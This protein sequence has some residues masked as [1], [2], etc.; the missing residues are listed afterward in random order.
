MKRRFFAIALT[1]AL[2]MAAAAPLTAGAE[3]E[4]I[5]DGTVTLSVFYPFHN[6]AIVSLADNQTVQKLEEM[7]GVRIEW[8]HPARGQEQEQFNLMMASNTLPDIINPGGEGNQFYPG[9]AAKAVEDGVFLRLNE[10]LDQYSQYYWPMVSAD[11]DFRRDAVMDDGTAYGFAML[12]KE[13][14]GTYS[15][16][17]VRQDWLDE[18]GLEQPTTIDELEIV[19]TAFK[20]RKGAETP[21]LLPSKGYDE[22]TMMLMA[23]FD[24][25]HAFYQ[26]D[27]QARWGAWED[28]FKLYLEKMNDWYNKGLIPSDFSTMDDSQ[29]NAAKSTGKAGLYKIG[30]WELE[31]ARKNSVDPDNFRVVALKTPYYLDEGEPSLRFTNSKVRGFFTSITGSCENPEAAVKWMDAWYSPEMTELCNWGFEGLTYYVGEDG[32]KHLSD[33][34]ISNPNGYSLTTVM[35]QYFMQSGTFVRDLSR[36]WDIYTDDEN[37]ATGIW[38]S[39]PADWFI[40]EALLSPTSEEGDELATLMSDI[41]TLRDERVINWIMGVEPLDTFEQYQETAR[42]MGIERAIEIKQQVLDRYNSR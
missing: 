29:R 11:P 36:E 6:D 28:N 8:L 18:L 39:T 16:L 30:F 26:V 1:A 32:L 13:A 9:G 24:T 10:L 2:A 12:E 17:G 33:L 3:L 37:A 14:Q 22:E 19:L 15:G 7:T 20:E 4:K 27:G 25:T 21:F 41:N 35:G 34:V 42:S 31:S 40:S 5:S 38:S 23:S